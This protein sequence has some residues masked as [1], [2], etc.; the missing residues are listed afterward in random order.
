LG[1]QWDFRKADHWDCEKV[2]LKAALLGCQT[3][4]LMGARVL[5]L[6][7]LMAASW[8]VDLAEWMACWL[9]ESMV[10]SMVLKLVV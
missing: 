8:A 6:V 2:E 1:K 3:V 4:G 5:W 10:A 7:E 9:V